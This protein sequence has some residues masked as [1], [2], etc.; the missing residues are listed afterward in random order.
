MLE[1]TNSLDGAH[2]MYITGRS[3]QVQQTHTN[4]FIASDYDSYVYCQVNQSVLSML[5]NCI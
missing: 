5:H 4:S 1:D 2:M 3:P